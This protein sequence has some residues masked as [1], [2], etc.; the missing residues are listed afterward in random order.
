MVPKPLTENSLP[1]HPSDSFSFPHECSSLKTQLLQADGWLGRVEK[2][3]ASLLRDW[4]VLMFLE[5]DLY[6]AS[7]GCHMQDPY[8][9]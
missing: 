8:L 3:K 7:R 4:R 9:I 6:K 1:S 5:A 2:A